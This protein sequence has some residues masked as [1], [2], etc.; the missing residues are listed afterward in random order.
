MTKNKKYLIKNIVAIGLIVTVFLVGYISVKIYFSPYK[1]EEEKQ[2]RSIYKAAMR[3]ISEFRLTSI[4]V[5]KEHDS[6]LFFTR[7]KSR[8]GSEA[9]TEKQLTSINQAV[10]QLLK[11]L[12]E[13]D[14]L[15]DL[16][17]NYRLIFKIGVTPVQVI[18]WIENIDGKYEFTYLNDSTNNIVSDFYMMKSV[19]RIDTNSYFND[20]LDKGKIEKFADLYNLNEIYFDQGAFYE[21]KVIEF[22]KI[23]HA[24]KPECK[25][26][27]N[28]EE[29]L[30]D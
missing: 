17:L 18:C 13:L 8:T 20:Y 7:L 11:H 29:L 22:S 5:D 15:D 6:V 1:T 21:E 3:G 25:I 30:F 10:E 12:N 19:Y 4:T 2:V 27:I 26:Y 24:I 16:Y 14:S 9:F 28:N 23:L